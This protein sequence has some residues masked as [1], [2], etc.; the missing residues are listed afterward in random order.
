MDDSIC[1][2]WG[3]TGRMEVSFTNM[4]EN[5]GEVNG[6]V[7]E[8]PDR[9]VVAEVI[10]RCPLEKSSDQISILLLLLLLF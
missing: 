9:S 7:W 10:L 1:S 2:G 6:G 5:Y 8:D 3:T 4:R